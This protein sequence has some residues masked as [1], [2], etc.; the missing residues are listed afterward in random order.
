MLPS[1]VYRQCHDVTLRTESA[2]TQIDHVFVSVYGVIVVETKDMKG[3]IFGGE[4]DRD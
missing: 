1:S 3:W 4:Q 2:T